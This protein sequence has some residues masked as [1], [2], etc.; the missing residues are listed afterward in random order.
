[1]R[2]KFEYC[3][4]MVF[5]FSFIVSCAKPDASIKG[6]KHVFKIGNQRPV[7]MRMCSWYLLSGCCLEEKQPHLITGISFHKNALFT[8]SIYK[9]VIRLTSQLLSREDSRHVTDRQTDMQSDFVVRAQ[10][11]W[12][13]GQTRSPPELPG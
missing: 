11:P 7:K 3:T 1:M 12:N 6:P 13:T 2:I 8:L 10:S 9:I 4:K 5:C